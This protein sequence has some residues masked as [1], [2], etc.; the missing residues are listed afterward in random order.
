MPA[1]RPSSLRLL[2]AR[3]APLALAVSLAGCQSLPSAGSHELPLDDPLIGAAPIERGLDA[4]GL[5]GLFNNIVLA[6]FYRC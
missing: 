4:E 5:A 6:H 3:L 1:A 2:P